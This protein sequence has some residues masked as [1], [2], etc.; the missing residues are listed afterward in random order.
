METK[1]ESILL[2]CSM[3]MQGSELDRELGWIGVESLELGTNCV[4]VVLSLK[5]Q[6]TPARLSLPLQIS[7]FS[8]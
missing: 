7:S 8:S 4:M 5:L 6:Q 2:L 1:E 3:A